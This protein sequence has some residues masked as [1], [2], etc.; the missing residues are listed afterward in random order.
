MQV[1]NPKVGGASW[2]PGAS[3]A[4]VVSVLPLMSTP[5]PT[6]VSS[7]RECWRTASCC[8]AAQP[9]DGRRSSIPAR[10]R[11]LNA[12]GSEF[13]AGNTTFKTS[14]HRARLVTLPRHSSCVQSA[15]SS[16]DSAKSR[17]IRPSGRTSSLNVRDGVKSRISC[18][19]WAGGSLPNPGPDR[20]LGPVPPQMCAR[21][22]HCALTLVRTLHHNLRGK[23][24]RE[25]RATL[26][27]VE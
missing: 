17:R 26:M 10:D 3:C 4:A 2:M 20:D 5:S 13:M 19:G 22:M 24:V 27:W 6:L 23:A 15:P 16:R 25:K 11:Q 12:P 1:R 8:R 7:R 21:R 18:L 14:Y 9:A